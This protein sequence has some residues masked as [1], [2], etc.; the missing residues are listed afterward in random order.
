MLRG[1]PKRWPGPR[2]T[3]TAHPVSPARY[4][5]GTPDRVSHL[6]AAHIVSRLPAHSDGWDP[7]YAVR[8]AR[9][10]RIKG[11]SRTGLRADHMPV[12]RGPNDFASTG[13]IIS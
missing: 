11:G 8:L 10:R 12:M 3:G 5:G 4:A 2:P 13:A 9:H 6:L 1:W 7:A